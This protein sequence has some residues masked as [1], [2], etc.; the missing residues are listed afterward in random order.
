VVVIMV[1]VGSR[2][3]VRYEC[4]KRLRQEAEDKHCQIMDK[5]A[6]D[7]RMHDQV[8]TLS[9]TPTACV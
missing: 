8:F 6:F 7:T 2:C 1:T 4:E 3:S 9:L 5:L